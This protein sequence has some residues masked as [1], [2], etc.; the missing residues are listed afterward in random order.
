MHRFPLTFESFIFSNGSRRAHERQ[1]QE[2]GQREGQKQRQRERQRKEQGKGEG[3]NNRHVECEVFLVQGKRPRPRGLPQVLGLARGSLLEELR[4]LIMIDSGASVHVC[5]LDHGQE[6][7]LRKS[8]GTRPLLTAS[9]AE[10]K[11]HGM[12]QVSYDTEVEKIM[13]DWT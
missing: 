13:T 5:P 1:R 12:R 4:E 2:Q 6:N 3:R 7:G 8:S 11:Q 10:M 9:G